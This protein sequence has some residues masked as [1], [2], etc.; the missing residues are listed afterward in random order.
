VKDYDK[1]HA[2][3]GCCCGV[4]M[5]IKAKGYAAIKRCCDQ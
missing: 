3:I 2:G 1:M 5:R 4:L